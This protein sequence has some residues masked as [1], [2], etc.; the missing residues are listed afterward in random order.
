MAETEIAYLTA[1]V[2]L[3][4]ENLT[5]IETNTRKAT[6]PAK[7]YHGRPAYHQFSYDLGWEMSRFARLRA[8]IESAIATQEF[9]LAQLKWLDNMN[10]KPGFAH[11]SSL[12]QDRLTYTLDNLQQTLRC[13]GIEKRMQ[14]HQEYVSKLFCCM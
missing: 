7:R 9:L 3:A 6:I 4:D 2:I 12:L 11:S 1:G 10:Q 13:D 8:R 5:N 14:I